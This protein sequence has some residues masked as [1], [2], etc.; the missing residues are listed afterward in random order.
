M[1]QLSVYKTTILQQ[2]AVLDLDS[3][4]GSKGMVP[5]PPPLSLPCPPFTVFPCPSKPA[6]R[7]GRA[8]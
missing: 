5:H 1:Q 8:L 6:R 7:S 4:N 3:G 2:I